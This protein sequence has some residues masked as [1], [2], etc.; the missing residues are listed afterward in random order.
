[1]A[2]NP[3]CSEDGIFYDLC[4][5]NAL[6]HII[7][8]HIYYLFC[9]PVFIVKIFLMGNCFADIS[10]KLLILYLFRDIFSSQILL[11][12]FMIIFY[13]SCTVH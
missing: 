3:L 11:R 5:Q 9:R 6:L 2:N 4:E 1:M 13:G 8:I 7:I 12:S 10:K